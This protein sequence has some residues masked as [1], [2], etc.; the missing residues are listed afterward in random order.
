M[1]RH[2]RPSTIRRSAI[3]ALALFLVGATVVACNN[4]ATEQPAGRV[5][6]ATTIA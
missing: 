4:P 6:P 1:K 5:A 2:D 3:V